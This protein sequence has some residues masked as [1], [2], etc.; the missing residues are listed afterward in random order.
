MARLRSLCGAI[1]MMIAVAAPLPGCSS[2][3]NREQE[4]AIG[5]EASPQFLAEGGGPI[6]DPQ[7]QQYVSSVGQK[8]LAEVPPEHRRDLPWEFHTLDSNVI[9]A[10]ALP[11]G[12]V[13]ITRALLSRME[14]E[15]QMAGVLGHEIGH[16]IAEH[17]GEQMARARNL[18]VGLAVAG[19]VTDAQW[20]EILGGG[21]GQL[22]LLRFGRGQELEAD[23]LGMEYMYR[24]GYKPGQMRKVM[25]ILKEAGGG[26]GIE[27]LQTHPHPGRRLDQANNLLKTKYAQTLDDPAYAV[28]AEQFQSNMLSRLKSLPPPQHQGG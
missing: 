20:I 11:G 12:K 23:A 26:G 21:A 6:P 10:F 4:I 24:A 25:R 19:V 7:I 13:F 22:Y 14:N 2:A 3:L 16:V 27:M 15:A 28:N 5:Q 1:L 17:I 9:N 18:N 8:L